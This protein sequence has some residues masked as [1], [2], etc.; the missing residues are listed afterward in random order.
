VCYGWF[1]S[2]RSK[3]KIEKKTTADRAG[4]RRYLWIL[5]IKLKKLI[6]VPD[7]RNFNTSKYLTDN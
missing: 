4:E 1:K 2:L 5:E 3:D 6:Y 7:L